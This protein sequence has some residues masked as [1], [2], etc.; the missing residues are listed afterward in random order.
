VKVLLLA[1]EPFYEDRGTPIAVN[2]LCRALSEREENVDVLAYHPGRPVNH[3]HV[4]IH[5]TWPVPFLRHIPPGLSWQKL[6]CDVLFFFKATW[7][8]IRH[9]YDVVHAVEESVFVA[10]WLGL[11][12]GIPYVYDMDSSMPQQI[13]ENCAPLVF[14]LPFMSWI[15]R[16]AVRGAIAVVV[17]C[18]ALAA[19]AN[20]DRARKVWV[21]HDVSLLEAPLDSA[22]APDP[23]P[24]LERPIVTY[25]GNLERY[26][27]IDLLISSFAAAVGTLGRGTLV[28]VGG[29]EVQI[30]NY[31]AAA[32]RLGIGA[33]VQ[34]LGQQPVER[35]GAYLAAADLLVSPRL[36]GKNTPMKIYSYLHSGRAVLATEIE[37]H[38]QVLDPTIAALAPPE[39]EPFAQR[40]AAL[41][42][43][44]LLRRRLG[45]AGRARIEA[46]HTYPHFR[47]E[48]N[49][50]YDWLDEQRNG[51][52]P[53]RGWPPAKAKAS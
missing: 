49:H 24:A 37:S 21:L 1:P 32:E 23:L 14:L 8:S 51:R 9:R 4:T 12:F 46:L 48:V 28:I 47:T 36:T 20:R 7:L 38:L 29:Q 33:R 44:E 10:M 3:E 19:L 13:V 53:G 42:Q 18:D 40:M 16:A 31:R 30:R 50:L 35:L 26:Q 2:M 25:I 22:P 5:R 45:D 27:G 6:V 15:E 11:L 43:D 17:M 34:F 52:R 39:V 41:M